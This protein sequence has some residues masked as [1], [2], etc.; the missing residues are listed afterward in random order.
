MSAAEDREMLAETR[1]FNEE[2]ERQLASGPSIH[3]LSPEASRQARRKGEWIYP[4]PVFLPEARELT[5]PGREG[6]ISLRVLAP[7]QPPTGAYLHLHGGGWTLGAADLQDPALWA[8]AQATGLCAVSV[9]YRL[10]PEHPYPAG[11][12]DCEDAANWLL[13]HGE[14][15]LGVPARYAIGGESA[16]A[17]LAVVTLLRLRDRSAGI[18]A[19][20]AANLTFG[21]YDLSLTPSQRRWGER[22][23]ILSTPIIRWFSDCFLAERDAESRRD[24]DISP[25]YADLRDLPA[26]LFTVGTLDPLIDDTMFMEARWRAAGNETTLRVWPEAIHAFTQFPIGVARASIESQHAFL[27]AAVG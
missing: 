16:G 24:P 22:N 3:T 1:A 5:I 6:E 18:D 7:E 11:P 23:L 21:A 8:L 9:D 17:H 14:G 13:E 27:R 12:D 20:R 2:L 15:E 26:A 25:L 19:F 10:G 4:E